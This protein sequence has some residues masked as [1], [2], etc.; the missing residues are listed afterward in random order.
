MKMKQNLKLGIAII[1]QNAGG[2]FLTL[3]MVIDNQ[4]LMDLNPE[5]KFL[6]VQ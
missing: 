5:S 3:Q 1:H 6:I 4:I 2:Q